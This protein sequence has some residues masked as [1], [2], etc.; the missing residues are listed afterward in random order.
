MSRTNARFDAKTPHVDAFIDYGAS[1]FASLGAGASALTLNAKGDVSFNMAASLAGKWVLSL[2]G[3]MQRI[4]ELPFLQEQFGT[5]AGVAGPTSVANTNDPDAQ[6]GPPPQT[7]VLSIT[8]Q[9]GFVAKGI[10]ILDYVLYYLIGTNPLAVH[11]SGLSKTVYPT[12]GAP[13]ALT[14][15][16]IVANAANGLALAANANVQ[17][18][19]I[20]VAAPVF[21]VSDLSGLYIEV[22]A[23]TPV[24]GTYR[25]YGCCIHAKFNFN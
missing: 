16:D 22:D 8:P 23:T 2:A 10:E 25:M 19:K 18:T 5:K 24:G 13:A 15:T 12:P 11:T 4:G 17:S 20:S 1:E 3:L 9:T 7:G 21:N 14:V 6:V